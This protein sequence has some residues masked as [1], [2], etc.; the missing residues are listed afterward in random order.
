MVLV[1][2]NEKTDATPSFLRADWHT[3]MESL[4]RGKSTWVSKG[5]NHENLQ[6]KPNDWVAMWFIWALCTL[7]LAQ[8]PARTFQE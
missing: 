4:H 5:Q 8:K 7:V 2:F 3:Q 1:S 6:P